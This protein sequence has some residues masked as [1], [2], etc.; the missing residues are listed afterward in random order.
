MQN[1]PISRRHLFRTSAA[2]AVAIATTQVTRDA[3]TADYRVVEV[4][5]V[6][7]G[8]NTTRARFVIEDGRPGAVPA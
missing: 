3:W 4:V 2:G 1:E 5:T 8:P 7:G 6:P